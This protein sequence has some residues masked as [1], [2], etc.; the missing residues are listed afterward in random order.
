LI[1]I[2]PLIYQQNIFLHFHI[3]LSRIDLFP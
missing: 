3:F 1:W 2:Y